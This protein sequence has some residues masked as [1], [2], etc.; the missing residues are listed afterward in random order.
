MET[1]IYRTGQMRVPTHHDYVLKHWAEFDTRRPEGHLSRSEVLFASPDLQ[2]GHW[3]LHD[4]IVLS[5]R[6]HCHKAAFNE[7][8]VESD[9]VRV[10]SVDDYNR[11]RSHHGWPT[12]EQITGI[13]KY[14]NSSMTLTVW[15]RELGEDPHGQWEVLLPVSEVI[16]SRT[17]AYEE[18]RE[19]Y[20]EE[21]MEDE[22]MD[23]LAELRMTLEASEIS[24]VTV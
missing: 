11:V 13:N 21:G 10:Y 3:W 1:T 9:N 22:I 8:T 23:K 5:N 4:G 20:L 19:L 2:G 7:I 15:L 17:L 6:G 12:P 14:W 16:S 24:L 18:I